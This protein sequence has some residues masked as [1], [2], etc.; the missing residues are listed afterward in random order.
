MRFLAGAENR[1]V[2]GNVHGGSMMKWMDEGAGACAAGW[3]G[4]PCVT[5]AVSG[6]TFHKPVAIG[7][8]VEVRAR[9]IHTG[10]TSMH[11]AVNVCSRDPRHGEYEDTT[12]CLMVFVALDAG[13][14]PTPVPKWEPTAPED[15]ALQAR[16]CTSGNWASTSRK[17]SARLSL[18]RRMAADR[19]VVIQSDGAA[20]DLCSEGVCDAAAPTRQEDNGESDGLI[21][22]YPCRWRLPQTGAVLGQGSG[23]RRG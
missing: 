11:I 4:L 2:Y 9:L 20:P 1:N 14:R 19:P 16:A 18:R 5:V 7:N 22:R 17:N 13:G 6:I 8:I 10:R 23:S 15:R 21:D 3:S 12:S